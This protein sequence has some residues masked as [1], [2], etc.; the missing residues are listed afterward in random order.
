MEVSVMNTR[1]N[2]RQFLGAAALA[3]FAVG[4]GLGVSA[5]E[6]APATRLNR[7]FFVSQGKTA[8]MNADGS[9][10]H[11]FEFDV[12]EQ[13][14][15]QP[16]GF[17]SDGRRVLFLSMEARRD[18][19]GRP[20]EQ[21]YHKTP[22]HI[23]VYHLDEGTLTEVA[24]RERLAVFCTPQALINDE[25]LLVQVVRDVDGSKVAQTY[26]IN[27]DG[28][29]AREFTRAGEGMP[30]GV[31]ISPDGK[32]VAY[33]IAGPRGYE[34]QTSDVDGGNRKLVAGHGDHL[35][36]CP[37]WSPDG[38]WLIF[39]D[40]LFRQDPGHDWSDLCLSRPDGTDQ[41]LLTKGQVL[42]FGA[43]YGG[44]DNRGGG[45]NVPVW[46]HDGAA[47]VSHRLPG[48]KVAWEYQANRPDTDHFNRDYKPE[49][50]RGG[51]EIRRIDP[52][53]DSSVRLT[54]PGPQVWDFRQSESTDGKQVVFCRAET[55][56]TPA[57]WVMDA[58]GQ[59]ARVL[60]K[61]LD[62]S[63]ADHPRWIPGGK[64]S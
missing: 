39:Q 25:R 24:N 5:E 26:S 29:D 20:F 36:F 59:N 14:T 15:W 33:H 7:F 44:V 61:G 34:I 27:L 13:E 60:T 23:W 37:I 47:L 62:D 10:L 2:R 63:G 64:R 21:Y 17:F 16:G 3:P 38:E 48:S 58:D 45:S 22:T 41:R 35:Y 8:M 46:T 12:P 40:C 43:T 50:A 54:Q 55:G 57:V 18:G 42:W 11:V 51:T 30:Y 28:T 1:I 49:L 9:G 4:A 53:D 31:N 52:R 19:P 32:R 6:A 56:G